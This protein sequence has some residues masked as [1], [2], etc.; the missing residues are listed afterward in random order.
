MPKWRQDKFWYILTIEYWFIS[1]NY[2]SVRFLRIMCTNF[3]LAQLWCFRFLDGVWIDE[4]YLFLTVFLL[5][6]GWINPYTVIT[7]HR[8]VE[9]GLTSSCSRRSSRIC[10]QP[11]CNDWQTSSAGIAQ[12][13]QLLVC[14]HAQHNGFNLLFITQEGFV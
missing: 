9:I 3:S 2:I 14:V 1:L 13:L 7:W 8:P 12:W 4:F 10:T 5:T 6:M 11:F